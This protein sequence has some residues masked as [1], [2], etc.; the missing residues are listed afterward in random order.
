TDLNARTSLQEARRALQQ[1][2]ATPLEDLG[3]ELAIKTLAEQAAQ[4]ASLVLNL[5]L[6]TDNLQYIETQTEQ[7]VYRIAQEAITNVVRH[8]EAKQLS[9]QLSTNNEVL[10][11]QIEDDG[12]GFSPKNETKSGHFGYVGMQE[13]AM[14]I[15]GTLNLVSEQGK[16]T[17]L[18]LAVPLVSGVG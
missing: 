18:T 12:V 14:V 17:K 7:G 15:G 16:G 3:L 6:P 10:S 1:L 2:R 11:L 9:I 13:R 4:Q 5:Q 8:A